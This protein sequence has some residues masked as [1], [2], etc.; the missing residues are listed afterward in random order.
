MTGTYRTKFSKNFL[1]LLTAVLVFFLTPG[2]KVTM[3]SSYDEKTDNAIT[4]FQKDLETFFVSVEGTYR[5]DGCEITNHRSF[6]DEAI[7]D[8]RSIK[9]RA[10]SMENNEIT[11]EQLGLLSNS[12]DNLKKLHEIDCLNDSQID[13]LRSSFNSHLVAILKFELAKKRGSKD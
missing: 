7:V 6:Y 11:I 1:C 9:L 3:V 5:Q 12:F 8:L 10:S 2:C 13:S 4:Q